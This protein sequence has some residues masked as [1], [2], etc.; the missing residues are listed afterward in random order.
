MNYFMPAERPFMALVDDDFHSARMLTRMLLAHG[1]PSVRWLDGATAAKLELGALM[2]AEQ[3]VLP[4]LVIVDL[5]ATSTA[6]REFVV[7]LR[8]LPRADELLIVAMAATL[9][10]PERDALLEVGADAV[11]ERHA[12]VDAYRREAA[13]L[14]RFWVRNQR[15]SAIG[16]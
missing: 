3:A 16:T 8:A 12:E 9:E 1:A 11:F 14:V 5:K 6:T 15:L 4:S 13:N 7:A 10:R 2:S